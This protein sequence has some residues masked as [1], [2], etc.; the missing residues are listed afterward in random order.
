MSTLIRASPVR[1]DR[2]WAVLA[3]ILAAAVLD[4]LDATITNVAAPTIAADLGGGAALI[5][6]LGAAYALAL[7]VLLVVG[8]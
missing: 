5:Q 8:G 4:L 2:R 6:W 7:G 1:A 3:V